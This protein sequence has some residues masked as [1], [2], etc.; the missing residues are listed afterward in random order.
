MPL[1]KLFFYL[2]PDPD[3]Y[4]KTNLDPDLALDPDCNKIWDPDPD[5]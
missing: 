3:P 4:W 5:P 2:D 1:K